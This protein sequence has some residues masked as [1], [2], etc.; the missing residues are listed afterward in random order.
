LFDA[1]IFNDIRICGFEI[2]LRRFPSSGAQLPSFR[3]AIRRDILF[4]N[5]TAAC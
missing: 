1:V 2:F 3:Y 5:V 4:A